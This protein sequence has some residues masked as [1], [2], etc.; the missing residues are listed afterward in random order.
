MSAFCALYQISRK[1]IDIIK[2]KL[3]TGQSAPTKDARG[4][5][6]NRPHKIS[7]AVEQAVISH[8]NRFP[9]EQSHY[10]Q[11]SNPHKRYL[12]PNL[13]M[14]IMYRCYIEDCKETKKPDNF[15]IKKSTYDKIFS[16]KFNL[17]F[18]HPK[19]DICSNCDSG[20]S[21]EKHQENVKLGFEL[22]S[23]DSES[24][25]KNKN[26]CYITVDL[27]QTMPLPKLTTSKAF[28]LE[29]LWFY[30]LGILVITTEGHQ[31]VM[32]TWTEDVAG[33]GSTEIVSCLWNFVS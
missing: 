20:K 18:S 3:A 13:N 16:C 12:A 6:G 31:S 21:N 28:Y 25:L 22:M 24:A 26:E 30:N 11:N 2:G 1:K 8:I 29:Q 32:Q 5:H 4:R 19:S 17:S 14:S 27:Q 23:K 9:T 7:D 10:S 33:R 15:L